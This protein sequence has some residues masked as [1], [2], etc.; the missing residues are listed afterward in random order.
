MG[1]AKRRGTFEERK[2]QSIALER[3]RIA[4]LTEEAEAATAM[5]AMASISPKR[6]ILR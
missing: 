4:K 5:A 3:Q 6:R 1:Q 2:Q